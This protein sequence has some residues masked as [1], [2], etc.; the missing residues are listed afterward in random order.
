M[1]GEPLSSL[2]AHR[3]FVRFWLAR[4]GGITASQMLMVAVAWQIYDISSSAWD[5]GLV[6]LFQFVPALV[7]SLP[8]GHVADR[9]HRGRIFA[10]CMA[11]QAALA[12]LLVAG[13]QGGL[14]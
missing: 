14:A 13:T 6:G 8:A 12:R 7:M 1:P 4:L 10:D 2:W 5:M 11:A 9:L 3:Q